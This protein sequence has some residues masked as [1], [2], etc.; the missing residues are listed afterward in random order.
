[1]TATTLVLG[2][3]NILMTDEAVGAEVVRVLAAAGDPR[4]T[5]LD[6]GTLSFT[7]APVIA[8]HPRLIV[9]DAAALGEAPGHLQVFTDEAMDHRL[10]TQARTV[11]EVSLADL[12]D[13]AR[14]TDSLP[15]QRALIGIEPGRIGW[16]ETL[17]PEVAAAVPRAVAAVRTLLADWDRMDAATP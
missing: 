11:H 1:M 10:T 9:I 17:T 7:L 12:M 3:G 14:L 4:L 6:G 5:C 16:G 15:R 8:D 13:M 2:V